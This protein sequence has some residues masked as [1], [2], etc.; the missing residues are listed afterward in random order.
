MNND[1]IDAARRASKITIEEAAMACGLSKVTY[2]QRVQHQDQF[3]IC[4]LMGLYD[5]LTDLGK[6]ILVDG[7][8]DFFAN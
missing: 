7:I 4:E 2:V 8:A 1:V 5:R 6:S 3:R